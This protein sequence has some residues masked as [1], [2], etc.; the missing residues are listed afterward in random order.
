MLLD[1]SG[2]LCLFDAD[3]RRH[4][5]ATALYD[6]ATERLTHSVVLSEFVPLCHSR[7]LNR[8]DSLSFASDLVGD[9]DIELVWVD[10]T[11]TRAGLSLLQSRLDKTYS[12]CDAISFVLMRHYGITEAL[13]TDH[14][15]AQEGML[16][17][18]EP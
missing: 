2:L 18:L 1:T 12:L 13:T 14:H 16:R 7:G 4:A 6:A 5:Q 17:L 8:M 11:L 9:P 15:F 10:E 3:D